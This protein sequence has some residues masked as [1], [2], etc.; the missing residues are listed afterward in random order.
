[1]ATSAFPLRF[2]CHLQRN[3]EIFVRLQRGIV[4]MLG[5]CLIFNACISWKSL[6]ALSEKAKKKKSSARQLIKILI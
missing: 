2:N 3:D 5:A 4:M 6:T 1:M